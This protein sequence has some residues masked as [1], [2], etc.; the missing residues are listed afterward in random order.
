MG[1]F[2]NL[3]GSK[4]PPED[5]PRDYT[6]R[7]VPDPHTNEGRAPYVDAWTGYA[8][9]KAGAPLKTI[10]REP[11]QIPGEYPTSDQFDRDD[12]RYAVAPGAVQTKKVRA[13]DPRWVATDPIR[14]QRTPSTY[15]AVQPFDWQFARQMNGLHFSMASNIRTYPIGG[16]L[17]VVPRRN[18]YRL[19]PPPRDINQTNLPANGTAVDVSEM[20]IRGVSSGQY[21][22]ATSRLR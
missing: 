7:A 10:G 20:D 13:P 18:T 22:S 1:W 15:R 3:F 4:K 19:L 12:I 17:P 16:M 8:D 5:S 21:R 6:N 11:R 14:P 9:K 2:A